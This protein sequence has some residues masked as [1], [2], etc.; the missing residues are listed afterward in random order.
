[1]KFLLYIAVPILIF[2]IN[3]FIKKNKLLLNYSG[4][5]HQKFLGNKSVPLTGGIFLIFFLLFLFYQNYILAIFLFFIFFVGF[6]SDIKLITSPAK[7]F[8]IQSIIILSFII[9][10]NL[11]IDTTRIFIL[12]YLLQNIFFSIFFTYFCLM[13]SIN[14]TNFI[15]G[16]NGLSLGYFII[17]MFF[18]L[19]LDLFHMYGL[20]QFQ[21]F[22]LLYIC[23]IILIFNYLDQIYLGD[24]GAYLISFLT[25]YFLIE[26]YNEQPTIS[27]FFIVL[28]LWYPCFENLF[29]IIRK[30]QINKSPTN[31]DNKHF[32]Q[33]LFYFIKTKTK[34]R[35]IYSNNISSL[36]IN[37]YNILI[38]YFGSEN[39]YNTQAL[40]LLIL[41][42]ILIYII[43]YLRLF[44]FKY[45]LK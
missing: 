41:L 16:L 24:A 45:R 28:L 13:I 11:N 15:D 38:F 31:P 43:T 39:I 23:I 17:I 20:E 5:V 7:R 36:I 42:N 30:F 14:G 37:F 26:I 35:N 2:F 29:S 32:H 9:L 18:V 19:K 33:L 1:M 34:L 22:F 27:P 12:D 10:L 8:I 21:Y 4:D 25:S 44:N 40:I 3:E 6:I